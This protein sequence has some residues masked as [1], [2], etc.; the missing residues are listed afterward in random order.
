MACS[1]NAELVH[2]AAEKELLYHAMEKCANTR[3]MISNRISNVNNLKKYFTKID[4]V[5]RN[6]QAKVSRL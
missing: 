1:A 6:W 3:E 2:L 4:S 5:S